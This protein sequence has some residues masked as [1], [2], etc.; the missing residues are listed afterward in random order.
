MTRLIGQR[1]IVQEHDRSRI[2]S[3]GPARVTGEP[4][5]HRPAAV[6]LHSERR[7]RRARPVGFPWQ[8]AMPGRSQDVM[9]RHPTSTNRP[10]SAGQ[11]SAVY[12]VYLHRQTRRLCAVR[13]DTSSGGDRVIR[14][15]TW[16]LRASTLYEPDRAWWQR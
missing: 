2:S 1:W 15:A 16:L 3:R 8:F 10:T 4:D 14:S 13:P 6:V 11:L 9:Q 7:T 12:L 5:E